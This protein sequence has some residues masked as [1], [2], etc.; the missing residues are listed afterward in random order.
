MVHNTKVAKRSRGRPQVR[1]DE[2]TRQLILAAA[3]EEF[4]ADGYA[5]SSMVRV[6]ERAGVS[7]KTM[8]RL[9]PTKAELFQSVISD[10]ISR[11]VL[12]MDEEHLDTLPIEQA[13]KHILITYGT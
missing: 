5:G 8:Y 10:R 7:T 2:E 3:R 6:A 11:F 13:L 4:H 9:I 12:E 1:P